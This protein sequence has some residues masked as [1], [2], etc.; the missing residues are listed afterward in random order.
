MLP[1]SEHVTESRG[2]VD[3]TPVSIS[4][5]PGFKSRASDRKF[6][7]VFPDFHRLFKADAEIM[8]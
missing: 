5:V 6:W 3:Y 8:P 7:Q 4:G 2:R 1:S